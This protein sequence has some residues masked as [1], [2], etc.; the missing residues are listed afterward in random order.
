MTNSWTIKVETVLS[1]EEQ[2]FLWVQ[3]LTSCA[4]APRLIHNGGVRAIGEVAIAAL[5]GVGPSLGSV[6]GI[7]SCD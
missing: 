7:H 3:L 5:S 1:L 6:G 2:P 4:V